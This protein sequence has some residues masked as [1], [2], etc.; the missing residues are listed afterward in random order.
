[1]S[2]EVLLEIDAGVA[3]VTL[4][5]PDR[6][7]ALTPAMAAELI[8]VFDEVDA[9]AEVGAVVVRGVGRSF[10]A[11]GDVQTLTD[12]GRDPAAGDAYAGMGLIYDSFYRLGQVKA[13]T[14][15]AVRGS[16][17]GAGMNMLLAADLRIVA[18]DVRLICGF[19]K[20]GLHPGGGHFV[21]LS[22][23]VG[24]EAAAAMAL[25]GEEVDGPTA[26]RLGLAWETVDD[27]AV[28]DRAL[29]L[30]GRVA[31]DPELARLATANFR[32]ET[33][34]PHVSWE[35]ATQFERPSQMWSMRRSAG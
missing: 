22:R 13:P 14:I 19:L 9:R 3:V 30:A 28:E 24:R 27:A 11:G 18:T 10:C 7:N 32:K 29:E 20:R 4:N 2:A 17:V 12:A 35:I 34:P 8:G 23:L 5:A 15:A 21:L 16:A 25:F 6:R 26:V 1:M 31:R 33:G